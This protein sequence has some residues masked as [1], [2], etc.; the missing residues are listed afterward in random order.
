MG[1][2]DYQNGMDFSDAVA[3]ANYLLSNLRGDGYQ[4]ISDI[5]PTDQIISLLLLMDLVHF[6]VDLFAYFRAG[7]WGEKLSKLK[8]T[9]D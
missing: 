6:V 9:Q 2:I 1:F 3:V 7:G 8:D 4:A 5:I